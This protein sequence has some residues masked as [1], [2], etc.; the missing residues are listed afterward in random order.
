MK[1]LVLLLGAFV[2]IGCGEKN[3]SGAEGSDAGEGDVKGID[4]MPDFSAPKG[5]G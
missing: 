4:P 3:E 1:K 5:G 2:L